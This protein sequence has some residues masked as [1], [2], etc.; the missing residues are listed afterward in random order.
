[1]RP[2]LNR[3]GYAKSTPQAINV[4]PQSL[5]GAG[6]RSLYDE[7]GSSTLELVLKHFRSSSMVNSSTKLLLDANE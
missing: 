7:Q 3:M 1:M 5:G 6:L 4:W 2:L